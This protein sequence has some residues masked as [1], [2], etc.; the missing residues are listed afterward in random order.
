MVRLLVRKRIA[1]L[2]LNTPKKKNKKED[3]DFAYIFVCYIDGIYGI[4]Y[5]DFE[6]HG[7]VNSCAVKVDRSPGDCLL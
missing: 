3:T 2:G 5:D 6:L 4:L 1:T 7:R